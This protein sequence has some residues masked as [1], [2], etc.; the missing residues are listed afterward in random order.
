M[1]TLAITLALISA[2]VAPAYAQLS[3]EQERLNLT[4]AFVR[5]LVDG[6]K[7]GTPWN[8][9]VVEKAFAKLDRAEVEEKVKAMRDIRRSRPLSHDTC[10][11]ALDAYLKLMQ[12]PG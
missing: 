3:P 5:Y 11:R 9:A 4:G 6:P 1:K 7:C 2:L 12:L 8:D 10:D